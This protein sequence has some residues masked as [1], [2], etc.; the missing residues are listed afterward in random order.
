MKKKIT[1]IFCLFL[2]YACFGQITF[3]QITGTTFTPLVD[4]EA[5]LAD[6][7]GDLDNDLIVSGGGDFDMMTMSNV[8]TTH[9]Y[10]NDGTGN[11]TLISSH[12]LP[13]L[14]SSS[15]SVGDVDSDGDL[16]VFI[17]GE[18]ENTNYFSGLYLNNGS[19][20]FSAST[21]S[22]T[23]YI[24]ADSE[25]GDVDG[26][27][28]LDIIVSGYT[29]LGY[30]SE[31]YINNGTGIFTLAAGTAFAGA[32]YA[33][34]KF[35]DIESDGDLDV[36]IAGTD[37]SSTFTNL[38][39]NDGS[40]TFSLVTGTPFSGCQLGKIDAA[41]VDGDG[42]MD[43]VVVGFD[44]ANELAIIYLNNGS[45]T[46][47]A[48]PASFIGLAYSSAQLIDFDLDSDVDLIISGYNGVTASRQTILYLNDGTG[49]FSPVVGTPFPATQQF[50]NI[51]GDI[52]G[53]NDPDFFLSGSSMG[54]GPDNAALYRNNTV[55]ASISEEL[56]VSGVIVFPNPTN[57]MVQIELNSAILPAD[58]KLYTLNGQ[59]IKTAQVEETSSL[60]FIIEQ[61]PGVYILEIRDSNDVIN[62]FQIIKR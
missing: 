7:D 53:D 30:L 8:P 16:D 17:N 47:T 51:A 3:T 36:L 28:D 27:G 41:D 43:V 23:G 2:G 40:G 15:I 9:F 22:F 32:N 46:F 5:I 54:S 38:Y 56:T 25:F 24:Q 1:T 14:N 50:G 61:Q 12:G 18:D 39:T 19:G 11:F 34:V 13:N 33:S 58:I 45:G 26:D 57:G 44:G 10:Q 21:N 35:L 4:G 6:F 60:Q 20:V 59:L 31:L 49:A 48:S 42:D 29:N 37:G 55:T 52:D 62:R